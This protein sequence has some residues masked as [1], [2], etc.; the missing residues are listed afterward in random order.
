MT[1]LYCGCGQVLGAQIFG[2]RRCNILCEIFARMTIPL[3]HDFIFKIMGL[4]VSVIFGV[5][6]AGSAALGAIGFTTGGIAAGSIAASIQS[7]IGN[8]AAGSL[9]SLVQSA[10][11]TGALGAIGTA[12]GAV[13]MGAGAYALAGSQEPQSSDEE[14]DSHEEVQESTPSLSFGS[15]DNLGSGEGKNKMKVKSSVAD[16]N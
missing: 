7:G 12:A 2:A 1:T 13:S 16:L 10:G 4:V 9:F 11:M 14:E 15:L 5:I 8:V 3:A 6:A